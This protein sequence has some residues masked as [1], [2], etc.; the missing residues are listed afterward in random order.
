MSAAPLPRD[1]F[2]RPIAHRGLHDAACG[3]IENTA[4]AFRAALAAGYGIECDL[5]PIACGTPVVFHDETLDRLVDAPRGTTTDSLSADM[6]A[7]LRYRGQDTPILTFADLLSLVAGA[8]PILAEIKS[9]WGPPYPRFLAGIAELAASYE[10]PV[11]LM[12]FDPAVIAPMQELAPHVPRGLVSGSYRRTAGD[13]WWA[14][15]IPPERA[16]RLRDLP[17]FGSCGASFAAYE[18]AAL[19]APATVA[20]R[21]QGV[22]V[23]TWTV[24]SERDRQ[25]AA[26][27]ADAMIFE[28]FAP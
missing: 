20:L 27:H 24:R 22:P 14:D 16:A 1:A 26:A 6:L 11:A 21:A 4:P 8:V 13:S 17:D 5:R 18:V 7:R 15:Q 12:S 2:V 25:L 3:R 9:E 23:F 10:G 19:P 28:G